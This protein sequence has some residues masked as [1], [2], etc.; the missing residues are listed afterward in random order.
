MET[1]PYVILAVGVSFLAIVA[2]IRFILL[3]H[4]ARNKVTFLILLGSVIWLLMSAFEVAS[5]SLPTKL[6][7]FKM[8]YVGLLIVPTTWLIN[9]MQLSG[10]DRWV[11]RSNLVALSVVPVIT[12]L[13][14]FT[15]PHGLMWSNFTLNS[16]DPFFPLNENAGLGYWPL[17]VGYS[18]VVLMFAVVI[19]V[20]RVVASRSLYRREA[21]PLIFVSCVPWAFSAVWLLNP[22]IFMYI[23]PTP[24]PLTIATSIILWRLAYLPGA[25]VVPVA[26][27]MIFDSMNEA[28][29]ILDAQTRI[30]ELNPRAQQ[31][32]GHN[33][34]D[35]LGKPVERMWTEWAGVKKELDSGTEGVRELSFGVGEEKKVYE[36]QSSHLSGIASERPNLL[37]IFRDIT[38]RKQMEGELK[39]Y[40]EHLEEEVLRGRRN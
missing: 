8:H 27:E 18:Y 34:S 13:L 38:E 14:I 39:R 16:V 25:D 37:I 28:V 12:L 17:I 35:A 19:F 1:L 22:S 31:L 15:N 30:A 29:I 32:L 11:K 10:Y 6:V 21:F 3:H 36:M 20:R 26:H 33:L 40:S 24:L 23:D 9:A 7:F 2:A 4:E 5:N